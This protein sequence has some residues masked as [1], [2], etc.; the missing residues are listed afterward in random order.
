MSPKA[1]QNMLQRHSHRMNPSNSVDGEIPD[2][3]KTRRFSHT[4]YIFVN[5]V[6]EY[7]MLLL[8]VQ[9]SFSDIFLKST[10]LRSVFEV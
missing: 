1:S 6:K 4:L 5:N 3:Q 10:R 9:A 8:G 2:F 7:L